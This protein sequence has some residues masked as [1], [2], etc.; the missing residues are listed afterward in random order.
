MNGEKSSN[1]KDYVF[2]VLVA[3][4]VGG[5]GG[6]GIGLS[7]EKARY[8]PFTGVEGAALAARIRE[9][10]KGQAKLDSEI[11]GLTVRITSLEKVGGEISD[12]GRRILSVVHEIQLKL[13]S[14]P[15]SFPPQLTQ[16]QLDSHEEFN[17]EIEK[18]VQR[19]EQIVED[20]H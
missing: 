16:K 4:L 20:K 2:W 15:E 6:L 1:P 3:G 17:R 9:L 5:G 11:S 19:I 8:D 14:L 18:R 13:A 12:N 10:E 7:T